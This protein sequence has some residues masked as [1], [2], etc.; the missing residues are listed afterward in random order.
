[1]YTNKYT[2]LLGEYYI[3]NHF[4]YHAF[5]TPLKWYLLYLYSRTKDKKM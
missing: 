3:N 1:M 5:D 4:V 2:K